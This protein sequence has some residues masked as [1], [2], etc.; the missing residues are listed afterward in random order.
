M[1]QQRRVPCSEAP[2]TSNIP[3]TQLTPLEEVVDRVNSAVEIMTREFEYLTSWLLH[4]GEHRQRERQGFSRI[5]SG[6][7]NPNLATE[8]RRALPRGR[9]KLVLETRY[10]KMSRSSTIMRNKV[11]RVTVRLTI[12][13]HLLLVRHAAAGQPA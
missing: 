5:R 12:P 6:D 10:G 1:V 2:A 7:S 8:G 4:R 11:T 13:T 3:T 9:G